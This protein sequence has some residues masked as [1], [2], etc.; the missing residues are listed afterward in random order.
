MITPPPV[1]KQPLDYAIASSRPI[2][3]V[4]QTITLGAI[5]AILFGL[6]FFVAPKL[7]QLFK[8]FK[9][10]LSLLT[11]LTLGASHFV[12]DNVLAWPLFVAV[13]LLV[14]MFA[15][16]MTWRSDLSPAQFHLRRYLLGSFLTMIFAAVAVM[17]AVGMFVGYFSIIDSVGTM[18]K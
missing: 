18:K 11:R 9:A 10:E 14:P 17:M 7:E 15:T 12:R 8:D 13:P 16:A 3:S 4:R 2:T 5:S 6:L 1:Q